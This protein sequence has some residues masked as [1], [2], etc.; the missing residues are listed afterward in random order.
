MLWLLIGL[1]AVVALG[2]KKKNGQGQLPGGIDWSKV[3]GAVGKIGQCGETGHDPCPVDPDELETMQ[4][5]F[6]Y[7]VGGG[8]HWISF[9]GAWNAVVAGQ[10]CRPE[11]LGHVFNMGGAALTC[12]MHVG[13]EGGE[14]ELPRWIAHH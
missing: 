3:G 6:R 8:F 5:D 12:E 10:P 13:Y 1:A 9:Q 4:P 7:G 2:A 11:M 14:T